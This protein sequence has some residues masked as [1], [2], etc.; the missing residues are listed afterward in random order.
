MPRES[1]TTV[2]ET[3]LHVAAERNNAAAVQALLLQGCDPSAENMYYE[4][5]RMLA[6]VKESYP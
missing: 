6:A 1:R 4:T 2:G 5:P 3:P